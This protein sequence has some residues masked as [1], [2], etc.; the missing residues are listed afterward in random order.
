MNNDKLHARF[1]GGGLVLAVCGVFAL[2][3]TLTAS[4]HSDA[5]AHQTGSAG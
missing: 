3:G 1:R 5:P 2:A 4:S